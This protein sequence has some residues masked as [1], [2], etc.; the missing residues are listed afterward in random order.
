MNYKIMLPHQVWQ[1]YDVALPSLNYVE[2]EAETMGEYTIKN[3]N[4]NAIG[5]GEEAVTVAL[6]VY[7]PTTQKGVVLVV[8]EYEKQADINFINSLIHQGFAV[9]VPD[10]SG[11]ATPATQ[12]GTSYSYG[13]FSEANE[14]LHKVCPT[15]KDTCQ[16]LYSVIVKRTLFVME[17]VFADTTPILMGLGSGVE[18]AMQVAGSTDNKISALIA[19]NGSGFG[20][21]ILHH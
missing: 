1:D 20:E 17:T 11:V 3:Y 19:I 16:Y 13:N 9:Y 2:G 6:K 18:V 10:L 14:H 8:S 4:F 12:F 7:T 21:Y 15:A 5:S